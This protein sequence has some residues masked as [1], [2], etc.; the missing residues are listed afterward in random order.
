MP[1]GAALEAE[2]VNG[3]NESEEIPAARLMQNPPGRPVWKADFQGLIQWLA[4]GAV[5]P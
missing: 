3:I 5:W 2:V 1:A 4:S